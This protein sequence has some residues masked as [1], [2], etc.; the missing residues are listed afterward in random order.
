M[1]RPTYKVLEED[2]QRYASRVAE[3]LA[4]LNT[5]EKT[6]NNA[7]ADLRLKL[8][9]RELQLKEQMARSCG[10]MIEAVAKMIAPGTF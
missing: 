9:E 2:R 8:H 4:T 10:Q 3:L 5:Q 1:K 7:I 6:H